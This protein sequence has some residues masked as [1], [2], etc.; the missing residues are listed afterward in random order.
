MPCCALLHNFQSKGSDDH[1]LRHI[2]HN[3][4]SALF[5]RAILSGILCN[6]C[7]QRTRLA[8]RLPQTHLLQLHLHYSSQRF[9]HLY[10]CAWSPLSSSLQTS[11]CL[12]IIQYRRWCLCSPR[13]SSSWCRADRSQPW[14]TSSALAPFSLADCAAVSLGRFG[15]WGRAWSRLTGGA[16]SSWCSSLWSFAAEQVVAVAGGRRAAWWPRWRTWRKGHC[17]NLHLV[18]EGLALHLLRP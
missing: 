16:S 10:P 3:F 7:F 2:N 11:H 6:T 12:A 9:P 4:Y 5:V 13:W 18:W 14:S 1:V 15:A 8:L 17:F